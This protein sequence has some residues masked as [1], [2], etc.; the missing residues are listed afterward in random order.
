M[1]GALSDGTGLRRRSMDRKEGRMGKVRIGAVELAEEEAFKIYEEGKLIVTYS[2]IYQLFYSRP[3]GGVYGQPIYSRPMR[4]Q[5]LA[6][7]GGFYIMDGAEV[8]RLL[9]FRLVVG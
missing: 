6:K 2:K 8:N 3:Y 9:G 4:G 7:R 1:R 5:G